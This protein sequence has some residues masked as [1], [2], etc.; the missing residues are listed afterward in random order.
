MMNSFLFKYFIYVNLIR[1]IISIRYPFNKNLDNSTGTSD[2]I[3]IELRSKYIDYTKHHNVISIFHTNFCGYCYLLIE[4][5]RWASSYPEVSNWKFLSVNCT[6]KQLICKNYNITKLPTIKTYVDRIELPYQPPFEL[7]PLIEYLIKLSTPSFI[8][9]TNNKNNNQNNINNFIEHIKNGTSNYNMSISLNISEFYENFGYFSPLIE[10]NENKTDFYNC[11]EDLT[12]DKYKTTFYFGMK[13]INGSDEKIIID[14]DG[15]PFIFN[16]D[17]NCTNVDLFLEKHIFPLVTI[18]TD[19]SFFYNLNK[20]HKL[21]VMLFGFLSNNKTKNFVNNEYKHLAYGKEKLIFSF[22]NYTNTSEINRYFK[23]K[24]YSRTELKLV[25]FDFNRSMYYI[26]PLVYD[27]DYNQ[28]EEM[29]HDYNLTLSNL[30]AIEFTTG[31]LFKDILIR[32]GF[33]EIT[34]TLVLVLV[35]GLLIIVCIIS[36]IFFEFCKKFCPSEIEEDENIEVN[37]EDKNK[38]NKNE[39]NKIQNDNKNTKMKIE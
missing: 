16:W 28:P 2:L 1:I 6:R 38:N 22:L 37:N 17:G 33:E 30:S 25:I 7:K 4:I 14:N 39:T 13:K 5:F 24:L 35:S 10:Y 27:V 23:V 21:L 11:I 12:N 34:T 20:K 18:I 19:N 36:F 32:F 15:A 29:L 26:H 3:E 31:Y 8:E 9:I